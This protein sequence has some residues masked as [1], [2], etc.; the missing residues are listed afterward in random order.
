MLDREQV[1]LDI[2]SI[3][4]MIKGK[5][6][7]VTGAGGSIGSELCSHILEHSPE[8]LIMLDRG[9]NYLYELKNIEKNHEDYINNKK[10]IVSD[11]LKKFI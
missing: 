7:L 9:E 10:V 2:N 6:V 11:K 1:S 8:A 5:K 4:E 3:K